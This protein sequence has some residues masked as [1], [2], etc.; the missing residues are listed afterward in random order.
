[1]KQI[2][3]LVD[4]VR[5][6]DPNICALILFG[7]TARLTPHRFSDADLLILC[8]RPQ[9]FDSLYLGDQ[10]YR[11]VALIVEAISAEDEWSFASLVSDL[12]VS[13]LSTDLVAN[14]AR[15]GVLLYQR[16]GVPLPPALT[17]LQPYEAWVKRVEALLE[18]CQKAVQPASA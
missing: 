5:V 6:H 12:Q 15:D 8:Q 4:L 3:L 14:I 18:K 10:K 1:M 9:E 2:N 16:E 7:S 17:N 11:G 13:D